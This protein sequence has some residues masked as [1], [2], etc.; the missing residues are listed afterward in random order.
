MTCGAEMVSGIGEVLAY[1][2]LRER[3]LGKHVNRARGYSW[4]NE[5]VPLCGAGDS[6]L[7]CTLEL[8]H[9]DLH[10]DGKGNTWD[11]VR[12]SQSQEAKDVAV[13]SLVEGPPKCKEDGCKR[14]AGHPGQHTR[15]ILLERYGRAEPPPYVRPATDAREIVVVDDLATLQKSTYE[16]VVDYWNEWDEPL[17]WDDL[18]LDV[19]ALVMDVKTLASDVREFAA[20]RW[21]QWVHGA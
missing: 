10:Q 12:F 17:D 4:N 21:Q 8:G 15:E 1:C 20:F 11:T 18:R 3:H 13:N 19:Q 6:R 14:Y 5:K 7:S 9:D 2:E 16:R